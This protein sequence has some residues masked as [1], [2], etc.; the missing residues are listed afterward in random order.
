MLGTMRDEKLAHKLGHGF[1]AV[2]FKR[3]ELGITC[4]NS[5]QPKPWRAEDEQ[6][7]GT[8]PDDQI[9]AFLGRSTESVAARRRDMGIHHP[10]PRRNGWQP[11]E[12]LH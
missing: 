11:E 1:K 7:L 9:A 10:Q 4:F 5:K 6:M 2:Q 12:I 8:R 3:N